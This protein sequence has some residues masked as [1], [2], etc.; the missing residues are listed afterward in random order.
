V[1]SIGAL[2]DKVR[3]II[4]RGALAIEGVFL[5]TLVAAALV[6]LAAIQI[7]RDQRE[8][9]IALL[10]TFGASRRR[11]LRLVLSEFVALGLVAGVLAALLAN[12]LSVLLAQRLFELDASFNLPLWLAGTLVGMA[13]VGLLGFFAS[14]PILKTPPMQLLR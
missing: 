13:L 4:A 14:R 6:S 3:N 9:E 10:R 5:F 11:V 2:L 8:R 1:I 12:V 7:S